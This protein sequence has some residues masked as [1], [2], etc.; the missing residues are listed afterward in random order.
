MLPLPLPVAKEIPDGP[1]VLVRCSSS[2]TLLPTWRPVTTNGVITLAVA[3]GFYS[4]EDLA[5]LNPDYVL[6]DLS[7]TEAVLSLLLGA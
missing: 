1:I 3:T 4:A 2:G 7:N 5:K 6:P